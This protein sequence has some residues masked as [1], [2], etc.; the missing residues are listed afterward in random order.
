MM[1][2]QLHTQEPWN[3]GG[4]DETDVDAIHE[5]TKTTIAECYDH[6]SIGRSNSKANARRIA[7]CVNAL[8]GIPTEVLEGANTISAV[9]M[10]LIKQRDV[11]L[12]ALKKINRLAKD[13]VTSFEITND[14]IEQI[15]T[16]AIAK[17]E[18]S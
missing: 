4:I 1:N 10:K 3:L 9:Y 2:E 18:Q 5:E 13:D 16:E 15:S 7:A 12:E 6:K 11:Q 14:E 8:A 17:A